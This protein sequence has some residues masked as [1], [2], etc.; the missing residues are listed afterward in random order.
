M[1]EVQEAPK[2]RIV[3]STEKI[4]SSSAL[5][6]SVIS[7]IALLYQSYLAREENKLIQMQQSASV[8]P[9][10]NQWY[11]NYNNSFKFVV[12]NKGVGPAF[13]E[14]VEIILDKDLKFTN[15]NDFFHHIFENTKSLDTIPYITSTLIEGFV[16]PANEEIDILEVNGSANIKTLSKALD[17]KNI[18][19]KIKY[20][21]VYGSEWLLSN[22]NYNNRSETIPL[23]SEE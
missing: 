11:S 16:L 2:K 9:H 13:I 6:I 22:E 1:S 7:V 23:S 18:V 20:R 5:F 3:W 4:M 21:D 12:G 10:L 14:D 8:L 19:Y 17:N 15:T